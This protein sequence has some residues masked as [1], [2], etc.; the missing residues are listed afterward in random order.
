MKR[1]CLFAGYDSKGIIHDYVVYYL[2]EMSSYADIY[3]MADNEFSIQE[4][5]KIIPYVKYCNGYHHGKYDFGSWQELIKII[6]WEKLSGYDELILA[7]DSVFGPLYSFKELFDRIEKDKEWDICGI[8]RTC[9]VGIE[10]ISSYFLVF[11]KRA[12]NSDILKN[13]F[14]L[15][16]KKGY[17]DTV[18]EYE[19]KF[20]EKFY[21]NG[22]IVKVY[23]EYDKHIYSYWKEYVQKGMPFIKK[24]VLSKKFYVLSSSFGWED[25]MI[26]NTTYPV[27]YMKD[28][29]KYN[30]DKYTD[31]LN[32]LCHF[33]DIVKWVF[34]FSKKYRIVILLGRFIV[35]K[36]TDCLKDTERNIKLLNE[37]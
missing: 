5:E 33:K 29:V 13:H 27:N 31:K 17:L 20:I 14:L 8:N 9:E 34:Y 16:E 36:R 21:N 1:L 7:N 10:H 2:K 22:Y 4:Y 28:Y 11:R 12:F 6:G 35:D 30:R 25:F 18:L 23:G 19:V 24:K 32:V 37:D 26:N 15:I 3:Y